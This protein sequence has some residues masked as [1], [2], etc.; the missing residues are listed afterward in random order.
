LTTIKDIMNALGFNEQQ[1]QKM[2][3]QSG[4]VAALD[5][6]GGST[7]KALAAYGIKEGAWSDEDEMFAIVHRMRT[8]IVTSPSFNGPRILGAILFENTMDRDIQGRSTA[9]YLWNV[10]EIVP[11]LKVDNGL[12]EE[13]NGVRLMKPMPQLATLLKKAKSKGIFGT[14][15]RSVINR[16]NLAGI[17]D[18]INQQFE[19]AV[20]ILA[21]GLVPIVEPEVDI[22]CPEKAK[23]EAFLKI[24]ILE[25]LDA[26]PP[27]QL[28]FLKLTLPE[29]DDLYADCVGHPK[30]V[31]V[32][33]LSGGYSRD[34]ANARLR[35]NHGVVASFSRALVEGL[36]AQQSDA[37]FNA[38]LDGA[39]HS[40][41]EASMV[42]QE[43]RKRIAAERKG[44]KAAV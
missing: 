33:A 42:K 19:V 18:I 29:Q 8:R 32:L 5:Q 20:Q 24:F 26:L 12:A 37:E 1:L 11:F 3:S 23:A 34:E 9:N 28:V 15:M 41:F 14:K 43:P 27:G 10:K 35:R 6:S 13:K 30:V 7:P 44:L 40:I 31:R 22:H 25:K 36:T 4:F 39:V 2:K 17:R 21:A 16:L 38:R